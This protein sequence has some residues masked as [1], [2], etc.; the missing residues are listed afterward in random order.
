MFSC[1]NIKPASATVLTLSL[2]IVDTVVRNVPYFEDIKVYFLTHHMAMWTQAFQPTVP[3]PR[4]L[5]SILYLGAFD[6]LFLAVG[7]F[8]FT[9]RDF[10]S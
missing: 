9:R 7:A 10:K 6:L 1:F 4:L 2:F 5:H 3:W 8:Y